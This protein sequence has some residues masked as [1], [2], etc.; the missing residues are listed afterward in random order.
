MRKMPSVAPF[1]HSISNFDFDVWIYFS[2]S[3][4]SSIYFL[5]CCFGYLSRVH[6]RSS[7]PLCLRVLILLLGGSARAGEVGVGARAVESVDSN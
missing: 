6:S 5:E 1:P 4:V 3:Q 2:F 7:A